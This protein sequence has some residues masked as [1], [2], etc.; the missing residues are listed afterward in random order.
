MFVG[1]IMITVSSYDEKDLG[2][3]VFW[4]FAENAQGP[5]AERAL[6]IAAVTLAGFGIARLFRPA[7]PA[8]PTASTADLADAEV[9]LRC[10]DAR[11]RNSRFWATRR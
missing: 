10:L 11:P 4:R 3:N 7:Q 8:A 9:E 2:L 1:A 6:L 5:R